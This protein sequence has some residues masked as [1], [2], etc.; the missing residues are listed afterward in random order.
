LRIRGR[1]LPPEPVSTHKVNESITA[2]EMLLID[3]NGKKVGVTPRERAQ[4]MAAEAGLDLVEVAPNARPPVCRIC[5]NSKILYEQRRKQREAKKHRKAHELKEIKM[6]PRIGPHDYEIKMRHA[7]ELL[8]EGHR[9][10]MTV[11]IRGYRRVNQE[12]VV[13]LYEKM[14]AEIREFGDVDFNTRQI[15]RSRSV[16]VSPKGE[17]IE[18]ADPQ[19]QGQ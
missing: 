5:D 6:K 17:A 15:G 4:E 3:Q 1:P 14:V 9:V 19:P 10:K 16:I 12:V 7:T 8:A 11:E 13:R 18:K 2:P